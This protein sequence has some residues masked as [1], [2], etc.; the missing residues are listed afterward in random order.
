MK[1]LDINT[2]YKF[3]ASK[4]FIKKNTFE[5]IELFPTNAIRVNN[6]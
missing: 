5:N 2:G 1:K 4:I 3:W 6:L